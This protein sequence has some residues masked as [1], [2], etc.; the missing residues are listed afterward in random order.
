MIAA[1]DDLLPRIPDEELRA[2]TRTLAAA[3]AEGGG[4]EAVGAGAG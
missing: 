1:W 3:L 4:G 2:N